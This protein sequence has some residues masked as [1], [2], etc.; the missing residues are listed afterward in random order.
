MSELDISATTSDA[1]CDLND[2]EVL[3]AA[4]GG[5]EPYLYTLNDVQQSDPLFTNLTAGTY[6]TAVADALGCSTNG[7][8]TINNVE[9]V[10]AT[11]N[12]TNA[13]C[14]TNEG[15]VE[16]IADS[17]TPPYTYR[18]DAGTPQSLNVFSSLSS[19]DYLVEVMDA[20]N[21]KFDVN[22]FLPSG[23]SYQQ[24]VAPI[25]MNSCAV[26]GCHD[27]SNSTLPDFTQFGQVQANA[28]MIKARTQNGTMP[29]NGSLSQSEIDLIACWVDD[30]A[31]NN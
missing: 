3:L 29:P 4:S 9:G 1:N 21:C 20:L 23:V 30:G 10:R 6:A 16:V 27:G 22:L 31:L 12:L 15:M 24:S 13:G 7:M 26:T 18:L 28:S 5:E 25:M 11:T 17:G 2:G 8:V 19:G 14:A